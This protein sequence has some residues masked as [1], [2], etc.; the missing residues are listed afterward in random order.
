MRDHAPG[1]ASKAA[2]SGGK[3]RRPPP[4]EYDYSD[5]DDDRG[6]F[7]PSA[8]RG[9][10]KG[11]PRAEASAGDAEWRAPPPTKKKA[12]TDN[13]KKVGKMPNFTQFVPLTSEMYGT[14]AHR[15]TIFTNMLG[16]NVSWGDG[17]WEIMVPDCS[18]PEGPRERFIRKRRS[19]WREP[20]AEQ[21]AKGYHFEPVDLMFFCLDCQNWHRN[22]SAKKKKGGNMTSARKHEDFHWRQIEPKPMKRRKRGKSGDPGDEGAADDERR[23]GGD[24]SDDDDDDSDG[25]GDGDGGGPGGGGGAGGPWRGGTMFRPTSAAARWRLIHLDNCM[26]G[27]SKRSVTPDGHIRGHVQVL[28][29]AKGTSMREITRNLNSIAAALVREMKAKIKNLRAVSVEFDGTTQAGCGDHITVIIVHG[30]DDTASKFVHFLVG[31]EKK[32]FQGTGM[33]IA[34]MVQTALINAGVACVMSSST[35]SAS[36]EMSAGKDLQKRRGDAYVRLKAKVPEGKELRDC[37]E[38]YNEAIEALGRPLMPAGMERLPDCVLE[39]CFEQQANTPCILHFLNLALAR[40]LSCLD[41][42]MLAKVMR[43]GAMAHRNGNMKSFME[44]EIRTKRVQHIANCVE[45][46]VKAETAENLELGTFSNDPRVKGLRGRERDNMVEKLTRIALGNKYSKEAKREVNAAIVNMEKQIREQGLFAAMELLSANSG[47]PDPAAKPKPWWQSVVDALAW[48]AMSGDEECERGSARVGMAAAVKTRW[49]SLLNLVVSILALW[50]RLVEWERTAPA[51]AE[52]FQTP[53]ESVYH[54]EILKE[55]RAYQRAVDKQCGIYKLGTADRAMWEKRREI[56]NDA[57]ANFTV[58]RVTKRQPEEWDDADKAAAQERLWREEFAGMENE[59]IVIDAKPMPLDRPTQQRSQVRGKK[60]K[61]VPAVID[62]TLEDEENAFI[63]TDTAPVFNRMLTNPIF[64]DTFKER[65]EVLR[66]MLE[67][68]ADQMKKGQKADSFTCC[69]IWQM[70]GAVTRRLNAPAF[71]EMYPAAWRAGTEKLGELTGKHMDSMRLAAM[72]SLFAEDQY[73]DAWLNPRDQDLYVAGLDL[74]MESAKGS[75]REV[76]Q[77][78]TDKQTAANQKMNRRDRERRAQLGLDIGAGRRSPVEQLEAH[79][80]WKKLSPSARGWRDGDSPLKYWKAHE[81]DQPELTF[82]AYFT[83]MRLATSVECERSFSSLRG[84]MGIYRHRLLPEHKKNELMLRLHPDEA[85]RLG[86]Q[87]LEDEPRS[88]LNPDLPAEADDE[89]VTEDILLRWD[90]EE[91]EP[92]VE[93]GGLR[94]AV[95]NSPEILELCARTGMAPGTWRIG[96]PEPPEL[97]EPEP[98]EAPEP[99]EELAAEEEEEAEAVAHAGAAGG[100]RMGE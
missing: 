96:G 54:K 13:R 6:G 29:T 84:L 93:G 44:L 85:Y 87:E 61:P 97:E 21:K 100:Q 49:T 60:G 37:D 20:T 90:A 17:T 69:E 24:G 25:D 47:E 9:E 95:L 53:E 77:K 75:L 38:L 76:L 1:R 36:D 99:E 66:E 63:V 48:T 81:R 78:W 68:F 80:Q 45:A 71:R 51:A 10:T 26:C 73:W 42:G 4:V 52:T 72:A 62:L 83:M 70:I 88:A 82:F 12:K 41:H 65:L 74:V 22:G 98:E 57:L 67:G 91:H 2:A 8:R 89:K 16:E 15:F 23:D 11:R 59:P 56:V 31:L 32:F 30:W 86:M 50:P 43:S 7:G 64:C 55:M 35:D 33:S 39:W 94:D 46:A 40:T 18:G 19:E 79:I 3:R 92:E 28:G 5:F 27:H 34:N 14:M 58:K